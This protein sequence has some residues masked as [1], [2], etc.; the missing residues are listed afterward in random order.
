MALN[1]SA[2]CSGALSWFEV[3]CT[4]H[5]SLEDRFGRLVSRNALARETGTTVSA[6]ASEEL[7]GLRKFRKIIIALRFG[8]ELWTAGLPCQILH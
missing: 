1:R 5:E 8:L 3:L 7:Q 6:L 4:G 2:S